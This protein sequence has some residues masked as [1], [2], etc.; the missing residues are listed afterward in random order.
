MGRGEKAVRHVKTPTMLDELRVALASLP[1]SYPPVLFLGVF[2]LI[3]AVYL[4]LGLFR[5]MPRKLPQ[6]A[7]RC[8]SRGASW[9]QW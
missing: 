8:A 1:L 9:A 2:T 5:A 6:Q 4:V 3:L 7:V